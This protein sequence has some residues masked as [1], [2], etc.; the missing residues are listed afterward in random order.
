MKIEAKLYPLEG[1]QVFKEILPS[2]LV[3]DPTSSL[4]EIDRDIIQANI[5]VKF[6]ENWIKM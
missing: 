2:D 5:L 6:H 1:E 3:F 4:F